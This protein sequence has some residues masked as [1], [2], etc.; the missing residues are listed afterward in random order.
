MGKFKVLLGR[1][2]SLLYDEEVDNCIEEGSDL[3]PAALEQFDL[4]DNAIFDFVNEIISTSESNEE[5]AWNEEVIGEV[6]DSV[7]NTLNKRGYRI[8]YPYYD[9]VN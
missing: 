4:I 7:L 3:E 2:K 9:S 6:R 8:W 1:E 5:L